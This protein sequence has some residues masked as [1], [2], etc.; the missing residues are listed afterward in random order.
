MVRITD[1]LEHWLG[2]TYGHVDHR[3]TDNSVVRLTDCLRTL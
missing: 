1:N 2:L 3:I